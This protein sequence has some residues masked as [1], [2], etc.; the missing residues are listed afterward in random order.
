[1]RGM[2][3]LTLLPP[4][5]DVCQE[6]ATQ[7][8]PGNAHNQQSLYYHFAFHGQHGRAPTWADALAHCVPEVKTQ[9]A[10]ELRKVGVV[11]DELTAQQQ[12][13]K[14]ASNGAD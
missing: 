11:V 12:T 13:A 2:N 4:R 5:P 6:C 7:H 1:M 14:E 8:E 9:W 10:A 3:G